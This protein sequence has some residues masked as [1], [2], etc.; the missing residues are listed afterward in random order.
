[1]KASL[2]VFFILA[3][4]F[5]ISFAHDESSCK[6][7]H[8]EQ[9]LKFVD[10]EE[11]MR[12]LTEEGRSLASASNIRIYVY[13]DFLKSSASSSY[14]SY[15]QNELVPP[16]VS[17]FENALK[18][19][20]PV[21][22]NLVLGS[23]VSTICEHSTPSILKS[24]GVAADFFIYYDSEAVSGTE[25]ASTKYCYLSSGT[26]RPL[27]SRTMINR[28]QLPVTTDVLLHEKNMY[29]LMHEMTHA[30]GFSSSLY[31][32][33]I[34]SNGK[35]LSGHIK[36]AK[37][38]GAT[39]T[40]IDVSP[41]TTK[42]RN[43]FGCSTLQ[44]ALMENGGGSGTASS[45][46]E[47]KVFL[48][49]YMTSGSILGRRVSELSLAMLEG[50]GWYTPNYDYAE[51]FFFGQG[52]GCSFVTGSTCTNYDEFC[53]GSSKGCS[54]TGRGGGYCSSDSISDGCKYY[55]PNEDY[56][57]E[58]ADG[59]DYARFPDLEV[60]GR[61]AGSKCFSGT[62]NSRSSTSVNSFCFKYSCSGSGSSTQLQV[63][64]GSH[65][66]TCTG[67]G[68]KTI[69]GYYG[70]INCPDPLTFCNTVGKKYCPRNCMGR[71][72][73]SNGTCKCNSGYSGVD[74][75]LKA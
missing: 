40:F 12:A 23:S 60:Y 32:Y 9:D 73:C 48:Y 56:D 62:L 16:I 53:S 6:H 15:I 44:G 38:N 33:F 34:D 49:D 11:D 37:V 65:T 21:S 52:Q 67:E 8:L 1:M 71:G 28:N 57:C 74:C 41:L 68:T 45:H 3:A 20:Y 39:R 27:I 13:Y 29:T 63:Q 7:D 54:P 5:T 30:F 4:L 59:E 46:F 35:Q 18:V 22:G 61:G 58:N 10:V 75:A 47:R 42:L 72:S 51:P 31:S 24:G 26:K 66:I 55:D 43:H 69:D 19:K 70:S 25:I 17:Y 36:S 50:S 14:A 64:V 2:R